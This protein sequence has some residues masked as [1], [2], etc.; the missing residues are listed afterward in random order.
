MANDGFLRSL[1]IELLDT[2]GNVIATDYMAVPEGHQ[3]WRNTSATYKLQVTMV[4]EAEGGT[5]DLKPTAF[6]NQGEM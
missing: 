1:R 6:W 4:M 5:H 3:S 2:Y